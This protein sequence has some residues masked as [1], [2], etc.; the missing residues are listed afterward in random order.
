MTYVNLLM[1]IFN[2]YLFCKYCKSPIKQ[3]GNNDS[4]ND[5]HLSC[6]EE[7]TEYNKNLSLDYDS[8]K[9]DALKRVEELRRQIIQELTFVQRITRNNNFRLSIN[10]REI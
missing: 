6:F 8:K 4:Q 7:I 3:T 9:V 10:T 1:K 5:Y 2:S